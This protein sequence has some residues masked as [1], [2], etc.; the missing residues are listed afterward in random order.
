MTK[1]TINYS[2]NGLL[3]VL[4]GDI[5]VGDEIRDPDHYNG[6]HYFVTQ[7]NINTDKVLKG[8]HVYSIFKGKDK[9]TS[10]VYYENRLKQFQSQTVPP[11][12]EA[13]PA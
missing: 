11:P 2:N 1:S 9:S 8:Y 6:P 10:A 3:R 7:D 13:A 4:K 12:S 5:L